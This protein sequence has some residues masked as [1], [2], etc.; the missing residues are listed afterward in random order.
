MASKPT[1]RALK[2]KV[3]ELLILQQHHER[4]KALEQE[5]KQDMLALNH[6]DIDIGEAGRVFIAETERVSFA[7]ETVIDI[8]GEQLAEKMIVIKRTVSNDILKAF[9][10]AGE[11]SE[12]NQQLLMKRADRKPVINLYVR[13]LK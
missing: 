6:R 3:S 10:A 4:Y 1:V 2:E 11:I 13:P 8:L 12:A 9:Y 5:V 7:P